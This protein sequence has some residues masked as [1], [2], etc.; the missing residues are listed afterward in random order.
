MAKLSL[1]PELTSLELEGSRCHQQAPARLICQARDRTWN[2]R[3]A[4]QALHQLSHHLSL[5]HSLSNVDPFLF[6]PNVEKTL[7]TLADTT[8]VA[9]AAMC[10]LSDHSPIHPMAHLLSKR[11]SPGR[12]ATPEHTHLPD[13]SFYNMLHTSVSS[14]KINRAC[15]W[16]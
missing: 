2:F 11:P 5:S 6:V 7:K 4:R 12:K 10:S 16:N 8:T 1:T 9:M 14:S 3:Y 13:S 15:F